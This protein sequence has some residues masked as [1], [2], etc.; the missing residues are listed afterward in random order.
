MKLS[1]SVGSNRAKFD[2]TPPDFDSTATM[3]RKLAAAIPL[4]ILLLTGITEGRERSFRMVFPERP[5]G[6]PKVAYLFDGTNSRLVTLPSMNLSEEILLPKGEL[7]I[8]LTAE[9][10]KVPELLPANAP[11]LRIPETLVDFYIIVTPDPENKHLPVKMN[12]VDAGEGKLK[13]G[14]TLWFNLTDH[15]IVAKLGDARMAVDPMGKTVSRDPLRTS[16]YYEARFAYQPG[17][18]G[19]LAPITEQSWWH[20][21]KSR[22]LGFIANTGGKLPKIYF[23]RDFRLP[24]EAR[25]G[26]A[27]GGEAAEAPE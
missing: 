2:R 6:A 25:G 13:P 16:G 17:G 9:E 11:S 5:R 4:V 24:P 21:D 23:F 15:K 7:R 10:V 22:H 3:K 27:G 1:L 8:V 14:E 26:E 20:D 19:E 18:T 12:I